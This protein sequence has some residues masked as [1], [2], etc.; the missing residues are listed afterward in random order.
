MPPGTGDLGSCWFD[1]PEAF[2][3]GVIGASSEGAAGGV[4]LF[5]GAVAGGTGGAVGIQTRLGSGLVHF[6]LKPSVLKEVAFQPFEL[7]E[8]DNHGDHGEHGGRGDFF[9]FILSVFSVPSVVK[10]Y[11]FLGKCARLGRMPRPTSLSSFLICVS[12]CFLWLKLFQCLEKQ[13][14]RLSIVWTTGR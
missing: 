13:T 1:G 3:F 7:D 8:E 12:L 10:S 4:A 6:L 11:W 5:H 2:A 14:G 9:N